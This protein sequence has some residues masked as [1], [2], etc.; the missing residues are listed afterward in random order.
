MTTQDNRAGL[1]SRRGL[2]GAA[3]GGAAAAVAAPLASLAPAHAQEKGR[4]TTTDAAY[5][6]T[7]LMQAGDHSE[8]FHGVSFAVIRG[9]EDDELTAA[10]ITQIIEN[11]LES[12]DTPAHG[13]Y[14]DGNGRYTNVAF[15]VHGRAVGQN[16]LGDVLT[17]G[18]DNAAHQYRRAWRI[19]DPV[20]PED[21]DDR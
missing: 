12:L 9:I 1:L 15:F 11:R 16:G 13:F 7:I 4:P 21:R 18:V 3:L 8:N 20:S 14:K 2:L 10:Q 17:S 19:A 5:Q 6:P